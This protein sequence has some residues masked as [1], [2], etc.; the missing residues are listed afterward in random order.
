MHWEA[1]AARAHTVEPMRLIGSP[2]APPLK[3]EEDFDGYERRRGD[4]I[5][6]HHT[7]LM[8]SQDRTPADSK[9]PMVRGRDGHRVEN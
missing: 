9:P 5:S 4:V 7:G 3:L 8:N 2:V 1:R 6:P